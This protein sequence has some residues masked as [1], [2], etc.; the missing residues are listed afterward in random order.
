M[1]LDT[2][3]GVTRTLTQTATVLIATALLEDEPLIKGQLVL[4]ADSITRWAELLSNLRDRAKAK[5]A[6]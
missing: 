6:T 3:S 1:N 5:G 4:M 2:L